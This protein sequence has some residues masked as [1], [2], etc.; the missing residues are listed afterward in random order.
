MELFLIILRNVAIVIA[1]LYVLL[2]IVSVSFVWSFASIMSHHNHDITVIL[3]N[4]RDNFIKLANLLNS[5]GV[6]IDKK[7]MDALNGFDLKRIEKQDGEDAKLAREEL[8][9]LGEHFLSLATSN[10]ASLNEEEYFHIT[11]NINELEKVYRQ[12]LM[13]YNADVL[14]YNFWIN[15][16]PTR[17]IFKILRF[18]KKD[19]I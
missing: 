12:H 14:G 15:F 3:T 11:T 4:K 8:T 7:Q 16:F 18:K 9:S 13:M 6:K 17:F 5:S 19:N 1:I 10:E 2:L